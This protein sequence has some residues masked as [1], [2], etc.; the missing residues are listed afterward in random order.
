MRQQLT[1]TMFLL[2]FSLL[3]TFPAT[4]EE[5]EVQA[6]RLLNALGCK[7]CHSF[8]GDGGSLAPALDQIGSRL[9]GEQIEKHLAAHTETRKQGFMP[10]YNTTAED[11]L[12]ILSDFLHK[13]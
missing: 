4:A 9:T 3:L 1:T 8:E 5:S 11:K 6:R 10:S 2:L 13:H 7:G 12:K